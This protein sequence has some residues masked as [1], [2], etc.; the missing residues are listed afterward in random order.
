MNEANTAI[1]AATVPPFEG[2]T[3]LMAPIERIA[4]IAQSSGFGTLK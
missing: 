2:P 3:Q 4:P 1:T